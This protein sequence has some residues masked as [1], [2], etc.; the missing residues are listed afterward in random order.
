MKYLVYVFGATVPEYNS[1]ILLNLV[2]APDGRLDKR[3]YIE[4]FS[5]GFLSL[6]S[7]QQEIS[8][9]NLN[10]EDAKALANAGAGAMA[11]QNQPTLIGHI[12]F[13]PKQLE[14][15]HFTGLATLARMKGE[16]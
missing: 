11:T 6:E 13:S 3:D 15:L 7:F 1:R 16:S 8:R 14:S 4:S 9:A 2:Q 5:M 12:E 10:S